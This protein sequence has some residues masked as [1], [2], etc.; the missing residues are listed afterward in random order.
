MVHC[1]KG[2]KGDY[3]TQQWLAVKYNEN[4]LPTHYE[5]PKCG[6]KQDMTMKEKVFDIIYMAE[7]YFNLPENWD[8]DEY[9]IEDGDTNRVY[10]ALRAIIFGGPRKAIICED[11]G[12][13][14]GEIDADAA[15]FFEDVFINMTDCEFLKYGFACKKC[16]DKHRKVAS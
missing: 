7:W 15:E 14:I 12:V 3:T 9:Y 1:P 4:K 6:Y 2:C 8:M 13:E 11:C 10:K 16:K 5:C